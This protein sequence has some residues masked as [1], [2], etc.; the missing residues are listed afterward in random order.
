MGIDAER[1]AR[2]VDLAD[3]LRRTLEKWEAALD[4]PDDDIPRILK[5]AGIAS[6]RSSLKDVERAITAYEQRNGMVKREGGP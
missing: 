3:S 1:Y 6:L 5:E 4:A 2:D